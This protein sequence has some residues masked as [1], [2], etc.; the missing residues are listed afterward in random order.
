[1]FDGWSGSLKDY[2][3]YQEE[4]RKKKKNNGYR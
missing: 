4:R 2:A 3:K 1:M